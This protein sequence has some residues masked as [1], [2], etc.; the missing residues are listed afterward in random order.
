MFYMLHCKYHNKYF[1]G[2]VRTFWR[3]RRGLMVVELGLAWLGEATQVKSRPR[4]LFI[5]SFILPVLIYWL[6]L[7]NFGQNSGNCINEQ[8]KHHRGSRR[9]TGQHHCNVFFF[10]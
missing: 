9:Q 1:T 6:L 5:V 7:R 10:Y 8:I 2:K 3:F 4:L